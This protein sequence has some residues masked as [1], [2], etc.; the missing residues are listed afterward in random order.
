MSGFSLSSPRPISSRN[1]PWG[2]SRAC[3]DCSFRVLSLCNLQPVL[4]LPMHIQ[5]IPL[6][7]VLTPWL[8]ALR[9]VPGPLRW[10]TPQNTYAQH[11]AGI[12]PQRPEKA[13]KTDPPTPTPGVKKRKI[14]D[15]HAVLRR[16]AKR[17]HSHR[18]TARTHL[19]LSFPLNYTYLYQV[20]IPHSYLSLT[21]TNP[22]QFPIPFYQA[23][24][25]FTYGIYVRNPE[26]H[27]KNFLML[28][29]TSDSLNSPRRLY[30][31]RKKLEPAPEFA[32][33]PPGT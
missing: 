32:P 12:S 10:T 15:L 17:N 13:A 11:T 21:D 9:L 5:S 20:S 8:A 27:T 1:L 3:K 30:I 24:L 19:A 33:A 2:N 7:F 28:S 31:W 16:H 23:A 22:S 29:N 14:C 6:P 4:S 25:Q 18:A 26:I